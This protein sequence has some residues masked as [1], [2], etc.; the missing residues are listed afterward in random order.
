M[1]GDRGA[2]SRG[3]LGAIRQSLDI[4]MHKN[5]ALHK[6]A[7]RRP[8]SVQFFDLAAGEINVLSAT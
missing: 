5:S 6:F 4:E 3:P 8:Q 7:P 2:A 1:R